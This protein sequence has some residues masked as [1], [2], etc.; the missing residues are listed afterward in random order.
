MLVTHATERHRLVKLLAVD[1][2]DEELPEIK[3]LTGRTV[4]GMP[5]SVGTGVLTERK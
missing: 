5:S 3:W 2:S 1:H 4:G